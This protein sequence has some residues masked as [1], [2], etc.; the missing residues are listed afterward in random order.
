MEVALATKRLLQNK[1]AMKV[2]TVRALSAIIVCLPGISG[3]DRPVNS[4]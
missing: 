3:P 4:G 1:A 2:A